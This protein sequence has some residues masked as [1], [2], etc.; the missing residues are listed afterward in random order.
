MHWNTAEVVNLEKC[1]IQKVVNEANSL[2]QYK[3]ILGL[4]ILNDILG[5]LV[6]LDKGN[7]LL[8]HLPK[9]GSFV[10]LLKESDR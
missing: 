1:T 2:Y 3:P 6:T 7:Y 5:K 10:S 4:G 9:H 8:A